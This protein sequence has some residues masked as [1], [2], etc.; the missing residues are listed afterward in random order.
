MTGEQV[1]R[2]RQAYR[3]AIADAN[4]AIKRLSEAGHEDRAAGL[5]VAADI[6]VSACFLFSIT[7][8]D[9]E[10]ATEVIRGAIAHAEREGD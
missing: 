2:A 5:Y 8:Q 6:G 10:R 1:S 7:D 4:A 3:D 9:Y